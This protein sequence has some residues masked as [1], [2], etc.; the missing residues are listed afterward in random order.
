LAGSKYEGNSVG[1]INY[2]LKP[3]D[4][5]IGKVGTGFSDSLRR[6]MYENPQ[7]YIGKKILIEHQGQ[8]EATRAFRAPSLKKVY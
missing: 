1:G 2:A 8:Y 6:E 4:A 7:K 5:I 3:G